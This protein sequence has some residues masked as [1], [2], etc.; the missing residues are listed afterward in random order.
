MAA[1]RARAVPDEGQASAGEDAAGSDPPQPTVELRR[2]PRQAA[3]SLHSY[4]EAASDAEPVGSSGALPPPQ[5]S[6]AT[7][8][9]KRKAASDAKPKACRKPKPEAVN[10]TCEECGVE[11]WIEGNWLLLC[12]T[13][14]K[15][16]HTRCLPTPLEAV[17]EGDW[18]CPTC[19]PP[20]PPAQKVA[21]LHRRHMLEFIPM[22]QNHCDKCDSISTTWRCGICDFDV[23]ANCFEAAVD[24]GERCE[25]CSMQTW[26]EGNWLLL[27]DKCPKAYHTRCLPTPL[28]AVPEGE[29]A[30]PTCDTGEKCEAC[31]LETWAEGN[32]LLLCD[33]CPKAYHTR[34]LPTP[35]EAVPEGEWLCPTCELH[36]HPLKRGT[37]RF[38][39]CDICGEVSTAWR[40][41]ICDF[42]VVR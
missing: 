25:V 12:D 42:D 24:T 38:N 10:D 37:R 15:A 35:L 19:N 17:P 7:S 39:H 26:A 21:K 41:G 20:P 29:W 22:P 11:T 16:Y 18:A 3:G 27:C 4:A 8:Q 9:P 32:W 23:C 6:K 13:C 36:P 28:E 14:P 30:C 2:A 31:G 34:C 40:C 1:G 33:N 5:K